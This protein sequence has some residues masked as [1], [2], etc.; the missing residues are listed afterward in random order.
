MVIFHSNMLVYQRVYPIIIPLDP[1][2]PP[3][4]YVNG[5]FRILDWR[6]LPYIRPIF[7]A[8]V[9]EYPHKIWPYMVQYLHFRILDFPLTMVFLCFRTHA[10]IVVHPFRQRQR[11]SLVRKSLSCNNRIPCS[12]R[13]KA[14]RV[15]S[16]FFTILPTNNKLYSLDWFK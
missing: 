10:I 15:M 1:I 6:Y 7:Q 13:M 2:K 11:F 3:F 14:A 5:H 4:S 16:W 9:R 8:Y 12:N